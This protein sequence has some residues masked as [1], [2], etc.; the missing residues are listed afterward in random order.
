MDHKGF[1]G[2][3]IKEALLGVR[4]GHGGP[5]GAIVVREGKVISRA[6]NEVVI[7]NDPTAHAE[8]QAIR[9]AAKKLKRFHLQDCV[10]YASCQPCPMCLSAVLWSRIKG[11][12]FAVGR[13]SAA[14]VGFSDKVILDIVKGSKRGVS[15]RRI[16][17]QD[18]VA[19]FIL[20]QRSAKSRKY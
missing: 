5:F 17:V 1:L 3:A 8:V 12:Y 11:V 15:Q 20:W 19:P 2:L 14:K 16:P 10:I 9:K 13:E 4:K 7:R 6:H 18:A